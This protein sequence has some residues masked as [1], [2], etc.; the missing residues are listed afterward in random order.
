M[1]CKL[2]PLTAGVA[3]VLLV[4]PLWVSAS[5]TTHIAFTSEREGNYEIYIMN[6]MDPSGQPLQNLTNHPTFDWY[7]AFSPNGQWMAFV[8]DRSGANRIYLMHRNRNKIHPLT[9]HLPSEADYDPAWSPDGEWIVFTS[10]ADIP[11]AD[12]N[13]Y[14]INVNTGDLQQLTD[15]GYNRFPKWSPDGDRI[16]FYSNRKEGNDLFLMKSNG[17]GV[18]RVIERKFGGGQPT[19][20]PDGQQIAYEMTDLAGVGIYIMTDE[21][22]NNRRITRDNTWAAFPAWSPNGEWIAYELEV[23]SAWGNPNRDSNIHLVSPDGTETRQLTKHP[24]IDRYPAWVPEAFLSVSPTVE[25]QTTLWGRL[26][27]STRD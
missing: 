12:P 10:R 9:N 18:R 11:K 20:S 23:E 24:A 2:M 6:T 3:C 7:P 26:K 17:N 25:K 5:D 4:L 14:K 13:I 1:K 21:G 27:Q 19:W 22:Q 8:S 16:L 15:T